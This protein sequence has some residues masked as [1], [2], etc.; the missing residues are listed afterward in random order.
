MNGFLNAVGAFVVLI[1]DA[2]VCFGLLYAAVR[3]MLRHV[4]GPMARV[5][6]LGVASG[7]AIVMAKN[8]VDALG[9]L[10]R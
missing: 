10:A 2:V 7:I 3:I 5:L 6:I 9:S 8:F 4:P 1:F